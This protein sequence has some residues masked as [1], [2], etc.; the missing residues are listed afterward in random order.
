MYSPYLM[1]FQNSNIFWNYLSFGKAS[2][3]ANTGQARISLYFSWRLQQLVHDMHGGYHLRLSSD[4][5]ANFLKILKK[6]VGFLHFF[7]NV[8]K[9]SQKI[10]GQSRIISSMYVMR[11]LLQSPEKI[12]RNYS[13]ACIRRTRCFSKTQIFSENLAD[14]FTASDMQ[15]PHT[16]GFL[17]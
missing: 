11:Q 5:F 16:I 12:Q 4:F 9:N 15:V 17:W 3:T 13:R 6:I 8:L 7:P 10:R 2:S 14:Y 1:L